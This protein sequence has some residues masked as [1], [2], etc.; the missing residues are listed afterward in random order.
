MAVCA[1]ACTCQN[2]D[3]GTLAPGHGLAQYCQ[4]ML[5]VALCQRLHRSW[6]APRNQDANG[7]LLLLPSP[8]PL[9]PQNNSAST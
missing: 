8:R 2:P 3:S 4:P 7:S 9:F 6:I 5:A 1:P